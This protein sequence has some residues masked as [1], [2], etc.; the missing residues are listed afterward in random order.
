MTSI[1]PPRAK[2][3]TQA[4]IMILPEHTFQEPEKDCSF[5]LKVWTHGC[6]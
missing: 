6:S 4:Q 5:D 1:P 2:Q 3:T